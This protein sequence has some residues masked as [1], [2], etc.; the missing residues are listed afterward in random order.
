MRSNTI[1]LG[2]GFG[3][4]AVGAAMRNLGGDFLEPSATYICMAGGAFMLQSL[5]K[6]WRLA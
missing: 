2:I 1:Q 3:L 5:Y 6:F 4:L